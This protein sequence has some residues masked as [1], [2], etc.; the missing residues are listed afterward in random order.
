M[1]V[2]IIHDWFTGVGGGEWCLE[3]L[4]ELFPEAHFFTLLHI[5]GSVLS[6]IE[7]GFHFGR[8]RKPM[9]AWSIL[10]ALVLGVVLPKTLNPQRYERLTE[11]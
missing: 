5:P 8:Q 2:A 4:Y 11:K 10:F 1:K 9:H 3:V 6:L 7:A